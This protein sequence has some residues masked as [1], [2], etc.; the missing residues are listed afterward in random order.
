MR[1]IPEIG[2]LKMAVLATLANPFLIGALNSPSLHAQS[3]LL[4]SPDQARPSF[5]VA[6]VKPIDRTT[7]HRDH[8]GRL[9]D[10]ETFVDRT[11]LMTFI[12]RAYLNGGGTCLL[13]NAFGGDCPVIAGT[14]PAWVRT[15]R[16]EI[17]A[18]LPANLPNYSARQLREENTAEVILMLQG[19]LADRFHLKVH[20]EM[21]ELPVYALTIGKNGPKLQPTPQGGELRKAADGSLIE[22]HGIASSNRTDA[23]GRLQFQASSMQDTAEQLALYFDRPVVDRT[24]LKGEYDFMIQFEVDSSAPELV[25]VDKSSGLGGGYVQS[26]SRVDLLRV[27]RGSPGR[28][29]QVEIDEGLRRGPGNRSRGE[30]LRQLIQNNNGTAQRKEPPK[31]LPIA[32][33]LAISC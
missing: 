21:K 13:K 24:G 10:R 30:T 3:I 33:D 17:Q 8:E 15:D 5:E 26:V 20:R 22:V 29:T 6:S 16:W 12:I 1:Y 32:P 27:V 23:R 19:L 25:T 2:V 7:M 4:G 28:R 18:K 9:F 14:L 31:R 11:D